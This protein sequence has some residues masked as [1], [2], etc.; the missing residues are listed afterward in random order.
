MP[1][2]MHRLSFHSTVNMLLVNFHSKLNLLFAHALSVH[3]WLA[4]CKGFVNTVA[5]KV[6]GTALLPSMTRD[7]LSS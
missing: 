2:G 7:G 1:H 4:L 6:I 3:C 5:F